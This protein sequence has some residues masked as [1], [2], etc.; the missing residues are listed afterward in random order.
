MPNWVR[1][2]LRIIDDN[3]QDIINRIT[4]YKNK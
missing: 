2:R 4:T 1:N 3:Y